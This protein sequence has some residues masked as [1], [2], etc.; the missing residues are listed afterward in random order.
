[1]EK[2]K[3]GEEVFPE[4]SVCCQG[5]HIL[6]ISVD[7]ARCSCLILSMMGPGNNRLKHIK[8]HR[9][10]ETKLSLYL[11][12]KMSTFVCVGVWGIYLLVCLLVGFFCFFL[13]LFLGVFF[14][15]SDEKK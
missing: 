9:R 13:E 10:S 1:M 8:E 2:N 4:L 7:Y 15:E 5:N 3:C 11:F 6:K 12:L 14:V